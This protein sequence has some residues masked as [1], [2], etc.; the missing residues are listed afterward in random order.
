MDKHGNTTIKN[1]VFAVNYCLEL[2]LRLANLSGDFLKWIW[3]KKS[4]ISVK[5]VL[6]GQ[7]Y[8]L[9]N[10]VKNYLG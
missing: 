10:S 7:N 2:G 1:E 9:W 8:L 6:D 3:L 4:G 5:N